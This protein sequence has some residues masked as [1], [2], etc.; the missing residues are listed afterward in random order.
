[1]TELV[2]P[3]VR[4]LVAEHLGV[5]G[6]ELSTDV[7]LLDDL[8]AD[9]LDLVELSL[10]IENHFGVVVPESALDGVRTY[11]D[12]VELVYVQMRGRRDAE[13]RLE[14]RSSPA[15]V[16]ARVVPARGVAH[17][18]LQRAGI[19]TPYVA[20]TIAEDAL[21]AGPGARLEVAVASS[22][23]DAKLASLGEQFAWLGRRGIQVSI[24]RDH[25]VG[26]AA[27]RPRPHAAA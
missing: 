22:V 19:L 8:A 26:S 14:A 5:D 23:S 4:A 17:G 15:M 3:R 24:R 9:S 18:D 27:A 12:L 16:W 6:E 2:E 25:H 11:G 7:S 13:Q 1:M 21:R 20:E 10:A